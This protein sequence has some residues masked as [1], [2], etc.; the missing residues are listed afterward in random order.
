MLAAWKTPD[1]STCHVFDVAPLDDRYPGFD[2]WLVKSTDA[3]GLNEIIGCSDTGL[4]TL[5]RTSAAE[6]PIELSGLWAYY[7][8]RAGSG[9][10]QG[11]VSARGDWFPSKTGLTFLLDFIDTTD[12]STWRSTITVRPSLHFDTDTQFFYDLQ[13]RDAVLPLLYH[14][15]LPRRQAW[16]VNL[17]PNLT[18]LLDSNVQVPLLPD[19]LGIVSD[20]QLDESVWRTKYLDSQGRRMGL[21]GARPLDQGAEMIIRASATTVYIGVRTP[22]VGVPSLRLAVLPRIGI[23]AALSDTYILEID[24]R[25]AMVESRLVRGRAE[26]PW[27]PG[28]D[29]GASMTESMW[30]VEIA[31]PASNLNA[32]LAQ[33][34]LWRLNCEVVSQ[35]ANQRRPLYQWGFPDMED[36]LHGMLSEFQTP[37]EIEPAR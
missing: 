9:F 35:D 13:S 37:R 8:N 2:R 10:R 25:G 18:C 22:A 32:A 31:I 29:I 7:R 1:P 30:S 3:A 6:A 36:A 34:T 14:E 33:N 20:G 4:L 27:T 23:P 5:R 24:E 12:N 28:L 17:E 15:L 19:E 21:I 11:V 16:A 26:K